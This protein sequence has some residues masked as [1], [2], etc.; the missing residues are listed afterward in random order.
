MLFEP[1]AAEAADPLS[2][3][4]FWAVLQEASEGSLR[5]IFGPGLIRDGHRRRPWRQG[6]APVLSGT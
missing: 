1:D 2:E 3:S 5:E 4:D 6:A